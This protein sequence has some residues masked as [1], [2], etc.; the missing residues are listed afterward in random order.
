MRQQG[1]QKHALSVRGKDLYET[2]P[3]A[4]RALVRE[5]E[6]PRRIWEPAAGRGAILR[7]L[8]AAGHVVHATELKRYRGRDPRIITDRDFFKFERA[9]RG[10]DTILTNPPYQCADQF[11]RHALQLVETVIVLQRFMAQEGVKRSDLI[12]RHLSHI[13]L[14]IERLPMMHRDGWDGPRLNNAGAPFGW[15]VFHRQPRRRDHH[16]VYRITWGEP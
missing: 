5:A 13:F 8:V 10:L 7:E 15:F 1:A 3:C 9:P 4:V 12:D 6:L 2:P 16:R 14:G 11:V